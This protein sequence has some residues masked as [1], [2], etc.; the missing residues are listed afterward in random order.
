MVFLENQ[1]ALHGG[2]FG[3]SPNQEAAWSDLAHALFNAKEFVFL[4]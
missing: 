4:P 2:S 3:S 1:T